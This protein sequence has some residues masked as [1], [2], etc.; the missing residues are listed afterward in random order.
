MS[1]DGAGT[2]AK[3]EK[4]FA[5][6]ERAAGGERAAFEELYKLKTREI[7]FYT[8]QHLNSKAD[9]EDVAQEVV[10]RMYENIGKLKSPYAFNA[11]MYRII[12][13][14]CYSHNRKNRHA[15][16]GGSDEELNIIADT[17]ESSSPESSAEHRER[18]EMIFRAITGMPPK[19]RDSIVM[20]Y[21]DEM[22]YKEIAEAMGVSINTVSTNILKGKK[23]L[24]KILEAGVYSDKDSDLLLGAAA[25]PA[26]SEALHHGIGDLV[27][28]A[29]AD[30][31]VTGCSER[32]ANGPPVKSSG[33]GSPS[34]YSSRRL[35]A[36]TALCIV[37]L[38]A[39]F[40][41]FSQIPGNAGSDP[42]PAP[43]PQTMASIGAGQPYRP[44]V[45]VVSADGST[46]AYT[47]PDILKI[48]LGD[49][50]G[51]VIE[52]NIYSS[53]GSRVYKDASG[54]SGILIGDALG[55]LP[56]GEYEAVWSVAAE[57]GRSADVKWK[58]VIT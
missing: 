15:A 5:L 53:T 23:T 46:A 41:S 36:I 44:P 37:A 13:F 21:Y 58:F 9:V 29:M 39:G 12:K 55:S 7:L 22:S 4:V 56:A 11:W 1:V 3:Q 52:S 25:M 26:I 30:R 50:T 35:I 38:I 8:M 2:T 43:V 33:F 49:D 48:I 57:D 51:R 54:Q 42:A 27:P 34:Q 18:S 19:Q 6:A 32:I 24:K 45:E 16:A 31:F 28:D 10:I 20:Y 40:Y 17:D 14:V 47:D